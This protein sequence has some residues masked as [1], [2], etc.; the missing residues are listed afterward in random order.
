MKSITYRDNLKK[1]RFLNRVK[2]IEKYGGKCCCC[3]EDEIKFLA[4]DHINNDGAK[5]RKSLGLYASH[6]FCEWIIKN[7]YP[8]FL[9]I[10]CHNCNC[11]KG[12][13]GKCPH[14]K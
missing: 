4:I 11:A 9:Q 14:V 7:N 2:V 3:G 12:Y 5:H 13:Y 10:L 1:R 8:D 6:S